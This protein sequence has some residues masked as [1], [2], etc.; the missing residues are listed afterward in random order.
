MLRLMWVRVT[1]T[2]VYAFPTKMRGS[3]LTDGQY[4]AGTIRG[5]GVDSTRA[6]A[7]TDALPVY[8][9]TFPTSLAA[10]AA[11]LRFHDIVR[12]DDSVGIR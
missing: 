10:I 2:T 4:Q 9:G 11:V 8:L 1:G 7:Y 5:T 6:V 3:Q 12:T